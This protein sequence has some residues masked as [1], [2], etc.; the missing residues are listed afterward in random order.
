MTVAREITPGRWS[1]T[2]VRFWVRCYATGLPR[3]VREERRDEITSDL[4]EHANDRQLADG[5]VDAEILARSLLGV[6]A[7]LSWRLEHSRLARVPSRSVAIL[8]RLLGVVEATARWIG[9]RGLP[10]LVVT[11]GALAG[12]LGLLVI[13]TARGGNAAGTPAS[14]LVAWGVLLLIGAAALVAGGRTLDAR[15]RLGGVLVLGGS[16]LLGLLLWPTIVAP[17]IALIF[18]WRTIVRIR[19]AR[20]DRSLS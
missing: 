11:S 9:R 18:G 16:T 7:D 4:W 8:L 12:L 19:R 1:A 5:D 3:N 6:P 10:G 13:V 2:F 15:P 17:I 20:R 14:D